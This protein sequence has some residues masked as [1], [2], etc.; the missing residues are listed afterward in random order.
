MAAVA[1]RIRVKSRALLH[2][3]RRNPVTAFGFG[4]IIG[5][6]ILGLL[7][8][9]VAPYDPYALNPANRMR[10]PSWDH[11]FGTGIFG[12]DI[13]SRVLYGIRIDFGIGLGAVAFG[14]V[15][16]SS[17]GVF[18][19]YYGGKIDEVLMRLMDIVAAFPG[20]ILAMAIAGVLGPSIPN[21]IIA[22]AFVNVPVY[23]RLSRSRFL[24]IRSSLYA[25][26]A[27]GVG[28]SDMRILAWHLLPNSLAPI[29][30]QSTLQCGWAI[31][32]AAGLSFIGLGVHLPTPEWGVMIG[33]GAP[34]IIS[35]QW[36]ISFFP[37]LAIAITVMGFNLIGDGLQDLLDPKRW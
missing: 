3:C 4:I 8:P 33:L 20:F 25:M 1:P 13:F 11:L 14:L 34:R 24:V 2:W 17:V 19:G 32:D 16:G 12:E 35:G 26:A 7:A 15:A 21:L 18:A 23:A 22:I 9:L 28:A 29:F 31:L 37:G 27:R 36:W 10:P 30:V 5:L 6:G